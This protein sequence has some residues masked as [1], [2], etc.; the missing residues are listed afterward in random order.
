MD[1]RVIEQQGFRL[2][3]QMEE[4]LQT[5][6]W[7]AQ[8]V[9]LNRTVCLQIL[10]PDFARHGAERERFL[11]MARCFAKLKSESIASVFDIVS[12]GDLHYVVMEH[13]DGPTLEEALARSGPFPLKQILHIASSLAFG[14]E[15]L[16][17]S[18]H[19]VHRNLKGATVRLDPRGVAKITD[20]SLAFV[21][22][23]GMDTAEMDGGHIVGAP[24]FISPEY[25]QGQSALT[26]QSDMYAFGALLYMLATGRAPFDTLDAVEIL[27]SHVR[28]QIVPPHQLNS[29]IPVAFSWF[30]HRL[31]MK[32]PVNR[33]A[34]WRAVRYDVKC[35][36]NDL[37]PR[38]VHPDEAYL[39]TILI[40]PM[41][42]AMAVGEAGDEAGQENESDT[43]KSIRLT[44]K[45][46]HSAQWEDEHNRDIARHNFL[47]AA[48]MSLLLLAWFA[49]LFWY[50]GIWQP[51]R[52]AAGA[53]PDT[54]IE[55]AAVPEAPD[56]PAP[57]TA[58]A[59][60]AADPAPPPARTNAPPV[61]AT[62]APPAPAPEKTVEMPKALRTAVA[63]DLK[64]GAVSI[65]RERL[66]EDTTPFTKKQAMLGIL[67]AAPTAEKLIESGVR[68]KIGRS[69]SV[70][71]KGRTRDMIPRSIAN[72][73]ITIEAYGRTHEI[74]IYE[75]TPDEKLEFAAEPKTE[76][77][78][79]TY[80]LML[81]GTSRQ[82]EV[83]KFA[84]KCPPLKDLIILAAA[85]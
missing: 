27:E 72:G 47:T 71:W 38:C 20:F 64:A 6:I 83:A 36:L 1:T 53:A 29:H 8:Q 14:L 45:A 23:P 62:N 42:A 15:Q 59:P 58:V 79:L 37:E 46:R 60:P 76:A 65:A 3:Q 19:V 25:A 21:S 69:L 70:N 16:W 63:A 12:D 43:R 48:F 35:L 55:Q 9:T 75:L 34:D 74:I 44:Q 82:G 22:R 80:C 39:S 24:C 31:M 18:A 84:A 41:L 49:L 68:A 67:A 17:D 54:P 85:K 2:L 78:H 4:T 52:Q 61:A 56:D 51:S 73:I 77:E 81:I 33:Y 30:I 26:T 32:N 5:D 66:A 10:K 11:A 28:A 57:P 40:E 13:V 50:R 7:K